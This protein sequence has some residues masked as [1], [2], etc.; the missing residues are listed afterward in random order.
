MPRQSK[1]R[2][3]KSTP[4]PVQLP[5]QSN[6][7]AYQ[8]D[9]QEICA[10]LESE[11]G[12]QCS[13]VDIAQCEENVFSFLFHSI[14]P[15]RIFESV[16][17]KKWFQSMW[18]HLF[19]LPSIQ[20]TQFIQN[21]DH[22]HKILQAAYEYL[23]LSKH[24]FYYNTPDETTSSSAHVQNESLI[25]QIETELAQCSGLEGR[26]EFTPICLKCKTNQFVEVKSEQTRSADEGMTNKYKCT[27]CGA[28]W[29]D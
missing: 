12:S 15:S 25:S 21:K 4:K 9:R 29:Q 2:T 14:P 17:C 11:Y 24:P 7:A 18:F 28:K 10:I 16:T 27:K 6:I 13:S 3:T 26:D 20:M 1:K 23:L 5:L 8:S 19:G 22:Q